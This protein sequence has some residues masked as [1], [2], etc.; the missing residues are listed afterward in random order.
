MTYWQRAASANGIVQFSQTRLEVKP[1]RVGFFCAGGKAVCAVSRASQMAFL[2]GHEPR[3]RRVQLGPPSVYVPPRNGKLSRPHIERMLALAQL[4]ACY[5]QFFTCVGKVLRLVV[6]RERRPLQC[7]EHLLRL[8]DAFM[9]QHRVPIITVNVVILENC[10]WR[11]PSSSVSITSATPWFTARI[12]DPAMPRL[13]D[14]GKDEQASGGTS[15]PPLLGLWVRIS[16]GNEW[17]NP[18]HREARRAVEKGRVVFLK[19]LDSG[20]LVPD[21]V[22]LRRVN[23]VYATA[24]S[25]GAENAHDLVL[26]FVSFCAIHERFLVS[27]VCSAWRNLALS[28]RATWASIDFDDR[29]LH[30]EL[31]ELALTRA[32][33]LPVDLHVTRYARYNDIIRNHF[34]RLRSL[35]SLHATDLPPF[36]RSP[37]YPAPLLE[38]LHIL[39]R[40]GLGNDFL[41]GGGKLRHLET[42][43][44]RVPGTGPCQALT[45]LTHLVVQCSIYA[46]AFVLGQELE[47]IFEL[48]PQ[49]QL[50]HLENLCNDS[51]PL[52]AP[53]RSLAAVTIITDSERSNV[54]T[55]VRS[56]HPDRFTHF[57]LG[58]THGGLPEDIGPILADVVELRMG[59]TNTDT[60]IP[61]AHFRYIAPS[62]AL[63]TL[64]DDEPQ[65]C[66][67]TILL[68]GLPRLK[69][70]TLPH[71]MLKK[72]PP[73][74][75]LPG[76]PQWIVLED[77]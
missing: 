38:R 27:W 13:A 58:F 61:V 39:G 48:C 50:L 9:D 65:E 52:G 72:W 53:P 44:L 24:T 14:R 25:G 37:E 1:R 34:D 64:A 7:I 67:T 77:E 41:G 56:W 51:L 31:L 4:S 17:L 16:V 62:T 59:P 30:P 76:R 46:P 54:C 63:M 70:I 33:H 73:L 68:A 15:R 18:G 45:T 26:L 47:R 40:E 36:F 12:S 22:L 5:I 20:L 11:R 19:H 10:Q 49:L 42:C 21:S 69:L 2:P 66:L 28:S 71:R 74:G 23:Q 35:T 6:K 43:S 29:A 32:A 57:E 55:R 3:L 8:G 75:T 60:E